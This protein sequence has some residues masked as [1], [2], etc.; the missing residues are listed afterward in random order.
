[1]R[2]HRRAFQNQQGRRQAAY[3]RAVFRVRD[4]ANHRTLVWNR[5]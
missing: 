3:F 1:V 2:R 5:L 4:G